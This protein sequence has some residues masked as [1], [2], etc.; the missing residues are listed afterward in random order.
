MKKV[1]IPHSWTEING[2]YYM[3]VNTPEGPKLIL[4]SE[5]SFE[6]IVTQNI[7]EIEYVEKPS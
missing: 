2:K 6:T 1:V 7:G 4:S 5:K 3:F